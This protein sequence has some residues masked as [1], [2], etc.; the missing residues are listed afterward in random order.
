MA[1]R[2]LETHE[3]VTDLT[4]LRDLVLT[5]LAS[6]AA[7]GVNPETVYIEG[8]VAASLVEET[9]T[10]GSTVLNVRVAVR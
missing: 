7:R 3:A 6:V 1:V 8:I 9:L 4:D 5:L 10:D 2:V